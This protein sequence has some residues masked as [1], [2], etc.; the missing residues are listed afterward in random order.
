MVLLVYKLRGIVIVSVRSWCGD[1][2]WYVIGSDR[3]VLVLFAK[4][5]FWFLKLSFVSV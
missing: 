5:W 2:L 3:G 4:S 1:R